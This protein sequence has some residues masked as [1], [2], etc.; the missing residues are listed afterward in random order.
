MN[1]KKKKICTHKHIKYTCAFLQ[2]MDKK[3]NILF[4]IKKLKVPS[5]N[6]Y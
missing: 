3:I 5:K 4:M 6:K 1:Q 2:I